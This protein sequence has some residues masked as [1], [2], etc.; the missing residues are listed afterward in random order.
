MDSLFCRHC[1]DREEKKGFDSVG[2]VVINMHD[3]QAEDNYHLDRH[4]QSGANPLLVSKGVLAMNLAN[5]HSVSKV[6]LLS[7][8]ALSIAMPSHAE[9]RSKSGDIIV[10][11]PQDLPEQAQTAGNSLFLH[12]DESGGTFLYIEQQQGARL[13]VFDVPD[14]A[15][16]KFVRSALLSA[17]GPFDFVRSL[18]DS[19]ELLRFRENKGVAVLDLHKAKTPV[20]RT[21]NSLNDTGRTESIGE[22]GLLLINEPF[23]YVRAVP[24]DY[25]VVDLSLPTN[26]ALLAIIPDVKHSVTRDETGTTYLLARGG[27]AVI[28]RPRVEED[29][30]R[31]E[32]SLEQN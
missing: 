8:S 7:V 12:L 16:V 23:D 30:A 4:S 14:P 18:G 26:P 10:L 20:L 25:Q 3:G 17:P 6:N 28:R 27:L 24:R 9:L 1:A 21:V 22:T 2:Q 29:Y 15:K 5:S 19:A 11:Q 31:H 32:A 13:D